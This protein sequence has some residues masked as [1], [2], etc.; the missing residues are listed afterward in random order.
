MEE[1]AS[2]KQEWGDLRSQHYMPLALR[3]V[4]YLEYGLMDKI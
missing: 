1:E 3:P 4:S 2:I